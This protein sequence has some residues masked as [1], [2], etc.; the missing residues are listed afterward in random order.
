MLLFYKITGKITGKI[1]SKINFKI[2]KNHD[3]ITIQEV[4]R[5]RFIMR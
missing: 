1:T 5:D 3:I 4:I 2:N